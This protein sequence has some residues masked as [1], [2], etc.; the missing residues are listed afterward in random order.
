MSY[1]LIWFPSERT[2]SPFLIY[3][4]LIITNIQT[5]LPTDHAVAETKIK[6][7]FFTRLLEVSTVSKNKRS[8]EDRCL[9]SGYCWRGKGNR[10]QWYLFRLSHDTSKYST[11]PFN[12]DY[13]CLDFSN[14]FSQTQW[15]PLRLT[16]II[17][18]GMMH[19]ALRL[20]SAV[21]SFRK[22]SD[23]VFFCFTFLKNF[24]VLE[25]EDR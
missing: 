24:N 22:H 5:L 2:G 9:I 23:K 3:S 15:V 7:L 14:N 1:F 19:A 16:E 11:P 21:F 4:H 17:P 8:T 12:W 6:Y 18:A 13:S 25:R 20:L 10:W